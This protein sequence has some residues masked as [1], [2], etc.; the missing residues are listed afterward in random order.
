MLSD[1]DFSPIAELPRQ[2]SFLQAVVPTLAE[3]ESVEAIWLTGSLARK[4]A[5]RWSSVDLCLLWSAESSGTNFEGFLAEL[6]PKARPIQKTFKK[7][8]CQR[9]VL[10][11][12]LGGALGDG[13]YLLDSSRQAAWAN[14]LHGITLAAHSH[15]E[16]G[17]GSAAGGVL[18]R[19]HWA[20]STMAME[21]RSRTGLV[22]PLYLSDEIADEMGNYLRG[23]IDALR[24][25]NTETIR[26]QLDRFWILLARLPGAVNRQE[27]LAVHALLAELRSLLIDLVVALN[28]AERPQAS[29]RINLF[30]GEAQREAFERSLGTNQFVSGSR[31]LSASGWIG[32]AVAL[33]VLYRWYAPQLAELYRTPYPQQAE[34]TV[35]G[36]LRAEIDGWPA[37]I[38]TG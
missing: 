38:T 20:S 22:Q 17:K 8:D 4:D 6:S 35:L 26:A 29:A 27:H 28:G 25:P 30:L 7:E 36:F 1:F 21:L 31:A 11:A 15:A 14:S 2:R 5:D 37:Q 16:M 9:E 24:P 13:G 12:A 23:E 32:Q 3:K 10:Q 18:F 19:I 34:E 33:I